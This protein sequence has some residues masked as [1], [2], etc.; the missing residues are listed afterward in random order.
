MSDTD[1]ILNSSCSTHITPFRHWFSDFRD[2]NNGKDLLGDD[3]ECQ[4]K[5]IGS[6]KLSLLDGTINILSDMRYVPEFDF[7]KCL[8]CIG[9]SI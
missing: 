9:Y 7:T 5:G 6:V 2:F 1:W 4:V 8:R 3:Y